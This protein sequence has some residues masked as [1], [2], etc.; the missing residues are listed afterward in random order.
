MNQSLSDLLGVN[1]LP[2]IGSI[3]TLPDVADAFGIQRTQGKTYLRAG[4]L[5]RASL[6]PAVPGHLKPMGHMATKSSQS[7]NGV[8]GD[9]ASDGQNTIIAIA[10][11]N[12]INA[13]ID[14]GDTWINRGQFGGSA[15]YAWSVAT[16]GK[17][18]WL[19][20]ARDGTVVRS[21]DAFASWSTT[22][23]SA[24]AAL[25]GSTVYACRLDFVN[26]E[27]WV[28]RLYMGLS[29]GT[30]NTNHLYRLS[31]S[32]NV[33][34]SVNLPGTGVENAGYY[35][36]GVFGN[37]KS[38]YAIFNRIGV[39]SS[40]TTSYTWTYAFAYDYSVGG[41]R[42]PFPICGQPATSMAW[43]EEQQRWLVYGNNV[44]YS[45]GYTY[46]MDVRI[47]DADLNL[48]GSWSPNN[49]STAGDT[50][51]PGG[52]TGEVISWG[53]WG[54]LIK[55]S[56]NYCLDLLG[57]GGSSI[58]GFSYF[59][60]RPLGGVISQ[61]AFSTNPSIHSGA[62]VK[63]NRDL[64]LIHQNIN[65]RD[66]YRVNSYVGLPTANKPNA[67]TSTFMRVG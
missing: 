22:L 63:V 56:R 2:P 52:F 31:S 51:F 1:S 27:F 16:D 21:T 24:Q 59:C 66:V 14:N 7:L 30:P 13:S 60:A 8:I 40:T 53:A 55:P 28:T 15:G 32:G 45:G 49:V 42:A 11:N 10:Y 38:L 20:M 25:V 46:S 50:Y 6:F 48:I 67:D 61:V 58:S 4:T 12:V 34:T 57:R 41:F 35:L 37:G 26:G 19:A 5:A 36:C 39:S 62:G 44:Y 17:G 54:A 43:D 9:M 47:Y 23:T 18:V 33:L 64:V 65:A 29:A 3:H